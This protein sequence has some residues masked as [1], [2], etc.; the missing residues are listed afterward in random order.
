MEE[1]DVRI[2]NEVLKSYIS[3]KSIRK[4]A[5]IFSINRLRVIEILGSK[6]NYNCSLSKKVQQKLLKDIFNPNITTKQIFKKYNI[7]STLYYNFF[8]YNVPKND[9]KIFKRHAEYYLYNDYCFS[10]ID[11]EEKA[12]WLGFLAADG[13]IEI[14]CNRIILEISNRDYNHIVKFKE[15]LK[16]NYKIYK[17]T[18]KTKTQNTKTCYIRVVSPFI[19]EDLKRLGFTSNKTYELK[20]MINK[21]PKEFQIHFL[22]GL[23]D[24]DGGFSIS[25]E[26][27][28]QLYISGTPG[29]MNDF[30]KFFGI[31]KNKLRDK[32]VYG[33]KR[34]TD[35]HKKLQIGGKKQC[36]KYLDAIYKDSNIRLYRKYMNYIIHYCDY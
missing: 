12:Y 11:T 20:S 26:N 17:R 9:R 22:R 21:I 34:K 14:K 36:K 23:F 32:K 8:Y 31:S 10:C 28:T 2:R 3:K 7:S 19:L 16:T 29:I 33:K 1:N 27:D 5:K 24:G 30:L 25:K 35:Y 18:R 15:F 6:R 13:S 4:I